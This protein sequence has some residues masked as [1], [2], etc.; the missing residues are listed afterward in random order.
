MPD[1]ASN[2]FLRIRTADRD[3]SFCCMSKERA[4]QTLIEEIDRLGGNVLEAELRHPSGQIE[5]LP[6]M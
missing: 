3:Y 6:M 1:E 2:W 5:R 4:M